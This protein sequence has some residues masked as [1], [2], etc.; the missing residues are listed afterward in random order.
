MVVSAARYVMYPDWRP[1]T[2]VIAIAGFA[3]AYRERRFPSGLPFPWKHFV[4]RK[5]RLIYLNHPGTGNANFAAPA[6]VN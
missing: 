3:G 6:A 2:P 5:A 1:V 4:I